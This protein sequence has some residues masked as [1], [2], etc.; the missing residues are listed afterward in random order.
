[1]LDNEL[2]EI[3]KQTDKISEESIEVPDMSREIERLSLSAPLSLIDNS[4]RRE[5]VENNN[6]KQTTRPAKWI[7]YA[8]AALAVIIIGGIGFLLFLGNNSGGLLP[9]M[10]KDCKVNLNDV[11][12]LGI[13]EEKPRAAGNLLFATTTSQTAQTTGRNYFITFD[14]NGDIEEVVFIKETTDEEITQEELPAWIYKMYIYQNFVYISFTN[15]KTADYEKEKI[16][17]FEME[18]RCNGGY[19]SFVIDKNTGKVY[20]LSEFSKMEISGNIVSSGGECYIMSVENDALTFTPIINN[21]NIPGTAK[22]DKFG[23]IFIVNNVWEQTIGNIV[24][25]IRDYEHK[26]G[27]DGMMYIVNWSDIIDRTVKYYNENGE[28]VKAGPECNTKLFE[29]WGGQVIGGYGQG[30]SRNTLDDFG[31]V[32]TVSK[33]S[34]SCAYIRDGFLVT[35]REYNDLIISDLDTL[36]NL[37]SY[38]FVSGFRN[39]DR[40]C[41]TGCMFD[42]G[43]IVSMQNGSGEQQLFVCKIFEAERAN[44]ENMFLPLNVKNFTD[45]YIE[46]DVLVV[47]TEEI[48]GTKTTYV[49]W[50]GTEVVVGNTVE[51]QYIPKP[52]IILPLN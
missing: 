14:E 33:F 15:I 39:V 49:Y 11:E 50:N 7:R 23:R 25:Y 51:V 52:I 35:Y 6:T 8:A 40:G 45:I 36:E 3:L 9:D 34:Y 20:S 24:F 43:L 18:Y 22:I 48:G 29:D 47:T 46:G 26:M 31:G 44:P 28:L 21:P 37:F 2:K 10:L 38:S 41:F 27:E 16:M 13:T 42:G 4:K 1:M 12:A 17:N 5:T 30:D 19:Q 32:Q